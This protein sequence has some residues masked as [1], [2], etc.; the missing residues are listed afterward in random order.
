MLLCRGGIEN[1]VTID[2]QANRCMAQPI[3]GDVLIVRIPALL[4]TTES[5]HLVLY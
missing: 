2:S 4:S 3:D 5:Q 1:G